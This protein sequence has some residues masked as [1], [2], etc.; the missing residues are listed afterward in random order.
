MTERSIAVRDITKIA[1]MTALTVVCSWITVPYTVPFTLQTFAVF[2]ALEFAGGK[3]GGISYL[4]YIILG[5]IGVPVFSG[6]N[7]GV[8]HLFGPTGGYLFGFALSCVIFIL[9]ENVLTRSRAIHA[10]VLAFCLLSCYLCG[11]LW[12]S[13]YTGR[14][15][16]SSFVL[17]VLPYVVP[18]VLKILLACYIS[19]KLRKIINN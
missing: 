10:S 2:F 15:L 5:G 17:C 6:F 9:F 16:L 13:V 8:G 14:A 18:D 12:F 7:G 1:L 11:T 19:Y 3:N 4:I